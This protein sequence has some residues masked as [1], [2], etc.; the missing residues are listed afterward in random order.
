MSV[1]ASA[2]IASAP[3]STQAQ[4][5][6]I[7]ACRPSFC[8]ASV[9][10]ITTKFASVLAST[11]ALTRSTISCWVTISLL[12]RWP[13]R[14][15]ATWSSMCTAAAPAAIICLTLRAMLN[16]PPQPVSISTSNGV[17]TR[18]VM[19]RTSSKTLSRLVMPKSGNP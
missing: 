7:T 3:A 15:C 18:S 8:K 13:Q 17:S 12:G 10:A 1:I 5:R 4:A 11:A 2:K 14:F 19:R 9:R 6:S 16:A